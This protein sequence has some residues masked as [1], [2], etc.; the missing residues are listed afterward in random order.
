MLASIV[1]GALAQKSTRYT[2]TVVWDLLGGIRYVAD[3]NADSGRERAVSYDGSK[4]EIRFVDCTVYVK[5]NR[6]ALM[7]GLGVPAPIAGFA[8]P[9]LGL[10][11]AQ[12]SHYAGHWISIPR[13]NP[14]Y[15]TMADGLTLASLVHVVMPPPGNLKLV[16]RK[17]RGTRLVD[18]VSKESGSFGGDSGLTAQA[19]GRHLPLA[20]FN[21]IGNGN[22][23][24]G[25]FTRWNEPLSVQA[26]ADSTPIATARRA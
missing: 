19:R 16:R 9:P 15:A 18:V 6:A 24:G 2:E 1:A 4:A 7:G 25:T 11:R 3:V 26:P 17:S 22:G 13:G 5:G 10:N 14:L 21:F 12:A 23:D 20:T 8:V